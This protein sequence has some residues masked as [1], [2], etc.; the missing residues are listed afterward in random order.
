[1]VTLVA[2]RAAHTGMTPQA[3]RIVDATSRTFP[4]AWNA[5][6]RQRTPWTAARSRSSSLSAR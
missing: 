5:S 4:L 3:F 6:V 1:V 2:T